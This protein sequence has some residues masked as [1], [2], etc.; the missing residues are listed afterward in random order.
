MISLQRILFP[1]DFSE[2]ALHALRYA[3]SFSESYQSELHVLHVV[4]DA[5]QYWMPIGPNNV[6]VGP[7]PEEL[8][9]LGRE[10]MQ[11]FLKEHLVETR[12]PVVS[13]VRLGRPFMEIIGYARERQIDMIVMGTHGRSGL[14][15]VLL[16]SVVEKVVRK[17]PCPVLTIRQPGRDFVMP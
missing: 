6:P 15:H 13:E 4:D 10:E 9:T 12:A 8:L 11:R 5:S 3:V 14:R 16:G 7:P 2:L 17:S 1:S